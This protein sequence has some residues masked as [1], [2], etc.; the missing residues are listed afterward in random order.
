M[1]FLDQSLI[2]Q[3]Y[4]GGSTMK[5]VLYMN[6]VI[7]QIFP[8]AENLEVVGRNLTWS[9]GSIGGLGKDMFFL[10]L[11]D[12]VEVKVGDA[13]TPELIDNNKYKAPPTIEAVLEEN[14]QHKERIATLESTL[15]D[16]M[17]MYKSMGLS[18][19]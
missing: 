14:R 16:M 9:G 7:E 5:L 18:I 8:H 6:N 3:R 12:D 1:T 15:I 17:D 13:V 11:E 10:W 19:K 4:E 2:L